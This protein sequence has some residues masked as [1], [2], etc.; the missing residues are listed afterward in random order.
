V[1][2]ATIVG[3][4]TDGLRV[5]IVGCGMV[6]RNHIEAFHAAS[7]VEVV[8]VSDVDLE[9]AQ[10]QAHKHGIP[11]ACG[12]LE[13]LLAHGVDIVSVCTPHP[14]HEEVV[15]AAARAGAHVLC[16]KPIA[17]DLAAAQRMVR[18]CRESGV[19][20]GVLFQRRFWPAA[21]RIRRAIDD[22]T[23][24]TPVLGHVSVQ[25]HRNRE[26]YAKDAWRGTW[27][28]GGGGVLM[29]QAVHYIDLVQWF[30]G[31]VTSVQGA[32]GTY[33]HGDVIEVEDSATAVL[34]FESGA[35]ATVNA[36]TVVTPALGIDIRVTGST[37]ATVGLREFPEGTEG[38][39]HLWA[40]GSAIESA[41]MPQGVNPN[42]D[43][44]QING[45]LVPFHVLQV[46]DFVEA[47]REGRAPAV[48]GED[49]FAALGIVLAVYESARSGRPV[50]P[51]ELLAEE[52]AALTG[53]G[54]R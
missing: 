35:M 31:R 39:N 3:P 4:G 38:V 33:K 2:V 47:V 27:G 34:T 11:F 18:V 53:E 21:Q 19:T 6:S 10:A 23:L 54:A 52:D 13:E 48:T 44:A 50:D 32:M 5:G 40:S 9:R 36:S 28:T 17:V 29:T 25:L 26:Y 24:G 42:A 1:H 15:L 37:G 45:R 20:L 49:A 16:E 43:L 7:G 22:G 14:T 8:A 46:A 51:A 12:S 30:M 41:P